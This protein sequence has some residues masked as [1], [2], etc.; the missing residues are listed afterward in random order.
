MR[1]ADLRM[2]AIRT[3]NGRPALTRRVAIRVGGFAARRR[4][5]A[6]A[7]TYVSIRQPEDGFAYVQALG[8]AVARALVG[9][10][11]LGFQRL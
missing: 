7:P 9:P 8:L 6:S 3:I 2:Q 4:Y 11:S 5:L 1:V 10:R